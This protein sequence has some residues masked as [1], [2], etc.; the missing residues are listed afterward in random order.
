[1]EI[2]TPL[3][4]DGQHVDNK[5]LFQR[6]KSGTVQVCNCRSNPTDLFKNMT[7]FNSHIKKKCHISWLLELNKLKP[8][9]EIQ[10]ADYEESRKLDLQRQQDRQL[11]QD[12]FERQLMEYH[13]Q[14]ELERA[15]LLSS[16]LNAAHEL[17]MKRN[18]IKEVSSGYNI[19]FVFPNGHKYTRKFQSSDTLDYVK[20][21]L[22]VYMVDKNILIKNY[23]IGTNFPKKIYETSISIQDAR[24]E[25]NSVLYIFNVDA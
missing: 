4:I 2:Y 8:L 7:E 15:I 9:K 24:I 17:E 11:A 19:R 18:Q 5:S 13:L 1:M 22:D 14:E 12:N 16:Q 3:V 20:I 23:D 10:N 21:V 6:N 25:N